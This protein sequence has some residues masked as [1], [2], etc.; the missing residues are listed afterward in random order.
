[1]SARR[2]IGPWLIT[3]GVIGLVV[4][5]VVWPGWW[6]YAAVF[7]AGGLVVGLGQVLEH[8]APAPDAGPDT[9]AADGGFPGP[10]QVWPLHRVLTEVAVGS[11]DWSWAEEWADLDERHA[12]TGY[13][14]HLEQQIRQNGI[15]IPVL[16]GSDGRLWDGH[17]RLRIAVR[18]GIGYVPVEIVPPSANDADDDLTAD[19]ARDLAAALG[20]Q[21]YRAQDALAFVGECCDIA[22]REHQP[23]TTARVRDWLKG[24]QCARQTGLVLPPDTL[25]IDPDT[26]RTTPDTTAVPT[27]ATLTEAIAALPPAPITHPDSDLRTRIATALLARIK[28]ATISGPQ[29]FGTDPMTR[30]LAATEYDL[31]DAVL[32]EV[33]AELRA[34]AEDLATHRCEQTGAHPGVVLPC[35]HDG[36]GLLRA[37]AEAIHPRSTP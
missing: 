20:L 11:G 28:Q 35:D 26:I 19:E 36:A 9:P 25:R 37:R 16:I 31:A 12:S 14:D 22:D 32:P 4:V 18:L 29:P 3:G 30:L 13:L 6:S 33:A 5:L 10:F 15:T 2:G 21:L 17:H 8:R 34:A 7:A 27:W 24:A 1:M 23:V